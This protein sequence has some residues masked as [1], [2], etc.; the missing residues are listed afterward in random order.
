MY[1]F[2]NKRPYVELTE[3]TKL[4]D[5]DK[6]FENNPAAFITELNSQGKPVVKKVVTKVDLLHFLMQIEQQ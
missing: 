3:G 2:N 5:I 4:A 6:F 1:N